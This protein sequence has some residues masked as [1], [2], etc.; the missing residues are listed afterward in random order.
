V[1]A[2]LVGVLAAVLPSIKAARLNVLTAIA[3]D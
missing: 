3:H 1:L 2:A